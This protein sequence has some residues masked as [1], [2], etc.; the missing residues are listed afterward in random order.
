[1]RNSL[2]AS[3]VQTLKCVSAV[4]NSGRRLA[5]R[6]VIP[7]RVGTTTNGDEKTIMTR[8]PD[9]GS[10]LAPSMKLWSRLAKRRRVRDRPRR[11]FGFVRPDRLPSTKQWLTMPS[12]CVT[13]SSLN[14]TPVT[15][16]TKCPM[17]SVLTWKFAIA[18]PVTVLKFTV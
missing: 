6:R 17:E 11:K 10:R 5:M 8:N 16:K 2:T 15:M 4:Q 7:G 12:C 18:A 9:S 1:M 13:K 3:I 14:T